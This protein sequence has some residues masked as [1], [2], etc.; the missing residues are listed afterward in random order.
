MFLKY[1]AD[2]EKVLNSTEEVLKFKSMEE[3][4]KQG[5]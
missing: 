5:W 3:C 1:L 4:Y 2:E